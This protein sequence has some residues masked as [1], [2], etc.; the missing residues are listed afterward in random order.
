VGGDDN[1]LWLSFAQQKH[2]TLTQ[3]PFFSQI[4]TW[5]QNRRTKWKKQM[6]ARL[7]LAQ[8]QGLLPPLPTMMA[9]ACLP[10]APVAPAHLMFPASASG[11]F[12]SLH[13]HHP[14][15]TSG[16][17]SVPV[18]VANNAMSPSLPFGI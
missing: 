3:T 17:S 13:F 18:S 12:H 2:G 6:A 1:I 5:F 11:S 15:A 10:P 14:G 16:F 4:K 7:R 9:A 8:R